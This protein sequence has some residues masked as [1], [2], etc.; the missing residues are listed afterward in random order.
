MVL[1]AEEQILIPLLGRDPL[2]FVIMQYGNPFWSCSK[3]VYKPVWHIPVPSVQWINSWRGAEELPETCIV[4]CRSKFGKL[5]HLVGF[6]IKNC[7]D[8]RSHERKIH[9]SLLLQRRPFL[10]PSSCDALSR[11][12]WELRNKSWYPCQDVT[13]GLCY[14]AGAFYREVLSQH[15]D[16]SPHT[17]HT[18]THTLATR[19]GSLSNFSHSNGS[20]PHCQYVVLWSWLPADVVNAWNY[21]FTFSHAHM[22]W[23][24]IMHRD[25]YTFSFIYTRSPCFSL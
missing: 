11:W 10:S 13:R 24:L 25:N 18:H 14:H 21:T 7:Y 22:V 3:A 15:A 9:G 16:D 5:V 17:Q 23:C 12:Y 6:I 4:S 8:A 2:S 1:R 20:G 19:F